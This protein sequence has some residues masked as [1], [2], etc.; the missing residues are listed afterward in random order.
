MTRPLP[1]VLARPL[2][3]LWLA[4]SAQ[5][6]QRGVI[7]ADSPHVHA[8]GVNPHR[9][10]ITGDGIATGRG[11]LTHDLGFPGHLARS[12]S[13]RTGHATDVDIVVDQN[14]TV[15]TCM[16]AIKGIDLSRYDVIV[17]SLGCN[18][19]LGLMDPAAWRASM[20]TLLAGLE[21]RAPDTTRIVVLPIPLFGPHTVLPAAL[22]KLVDERVAELN[23][24][25]LDLASTI[26][27]ATLVGDGDTY[28]F[29]AQESHVYRIWADSVAEHINTVMDPDHTLAGSTADENE[30]E[31]LRAL[32]RFHGVIA[33]GDPVLDGLTRRVRQAFGTTI[34]VITLIRQDVQIM[35]STIGMEP[36]TVPRGQTFCNVTIRRAG[37]LVIEDASLDARYDHFPAVI[38]PRAV[39]FYAGYPIE[40]PDGH[41]IGAFCVMDD[42]PR[43][44]TPD[45]L[46]LLRSLAQA[47]QGH[48]WRP[49]GT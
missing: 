17:L 39:R 27:R 37:H 26:A 7:A 43:H 13:A 19:V 32:E 1:A 9:L 24:V 36:E 15:D 45:D 18:E 23:A 29:R 41:R 46:A 12:L 44:F 34:S 48:L 11:V 33:V 5:S 10:L 25:T 30:R 8:P 22:V 40:S 47:A 6:W 3:R 31:R 14:M 20:G 35:I 38:G 21:E 16:H 42:K 28:D 4:Y 2:I 49:L